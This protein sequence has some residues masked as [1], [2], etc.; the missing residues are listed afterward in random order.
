MSAKPAGTGKMSP[1]ANKRKSLKLSN[2]EGNATSARAQMNSSIKKFKIA[3]IVLA[4]IVAIYLIG[5]LLFSVVF[6]PGTKLG[7]FDLSFKTTGDAENRIDEALKNYTISVSG[8]GFSFNASA[9]QTGLAVN[10]KNAVEAARADLNGWAWPI[11]LIQGNHDETDKLTV[12]GDT[13]SITQLAQDAVNQFNAQ[14]T[15]PVNAN[16]SYDASKQAFTVTPEKE[17]TQLKVEAVTEAVG[18]AIANLEPTLVLDESYILRPSVYSDDSRINPAI[19]VANKMLA[20][21]LTLTVGGTPVATVDG[22]LLQPMICIDADANASINEDKFVSWAYAAL[23]GADTLGSERT[24]T[25][26]DG[27]TCTVSG[28]SFGWMTNARELCGEVTKAAREGKVSNLEV[29]CKQKGDIFTGAGQRDWRT[30]Y[31]DVDITE[32]HVR[33][34]DENESIIWESDC[35]TGIPDGEHDTVPGVWFVNNKLRKNKLIGIKDGEWLYETEVEYWMP[36]E[37]DSIGFH[38]ATWQPRFGPPWYEWG[39]GSHGCVNL[40][41]DEA[42]TL[43]GLI[44]VGDVVVVHH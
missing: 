38:D 33:F 16:I 32:Q 17:G 15:A 11:L 24:F 18:Y 31:V 36:F 30:R 34:Y 27:K 1:Q 14:Q 21:N 25:R 9:A 26:P 2:G 19:E 42:A 37:D 6:P 22:N 28:G 12:T 13:G 5:T 39:A 3:G 8:D 43:Y 29:P 35:I 44:E 4:A 10:S 7:S 41:L 40:P 20:T 23:A